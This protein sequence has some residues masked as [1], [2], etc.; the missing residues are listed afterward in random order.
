[1]HLIV[2]RESFAQ[3]LQ[4]VGS[5]TPSKDT[6]E[7]L[8][9]IKVVADKHGVLLQATDAEIGIRYR[10][11]DCEVVKPG[12]TLLPTR[13]T[14]TIVQETRGETITLE[15]DGHECTLLIERGKFKLLTPAT[16]EFPDIEAFSTKL[17]HYT[18]SAQ[19][20]QTIIQHTTFATDDE[21][22]RYSAIAGVLFEIDEDAKLNVIATDGRRLAYET[23]CGKVHEKKDA[24]EPLA[25]SPVLAPKA[26]QM[27][28]RSLHNIE[29][30]VQ[31]ALSAHR[32]LFKIGE[33]ELI[34]RLIEGNFPKWRRIM[35]EK[36]GRTR[37]DFVAET[38]HAAVRQA[39][40]VTTESQPGVLFSFTQGTVTLT[41]QGSETGESQIEL[42]VS[43][44]AAPFK[45]K[46]DPKFLREF[47]R[48]LEPTTVV[49]LWADATDPLLFT[50]GETYTYVVMP[51]SM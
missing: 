4:I 27:L 1:M 37:I 10:L 29:G 50:V 25:R 8:H 41:A 40:I 3:A 49:S 17:P 45:F 7:V 34:T 46:I 26:L 22:T 6:K 13:R 20:L 32:A 44:D 24:S 16:E 23:Y 43:F 2:Q 11:N 38:L 35:P 33:V 28:E 18:M 51:L 21:N 42:P 36:E 47:L 19:A 39:Q 14:K 5:V 30:D 31:V 12:E 15:S 9:H 48:V